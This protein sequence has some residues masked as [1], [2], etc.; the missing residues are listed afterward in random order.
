MQSID[1]PGD[2]YAHSRIVTL[3]PRI[4]VEGGGTIGFPVLGA[5]IRSLIGVAEKAPYGRG[6]DAVF[7]TSVRDCWQIDS[8]QIRIG[9]EG[10]RAA[11]DRILGQVA[12]GLGCPLDEVEALPYKLLVY[13]PGGFFNTHR[14]TEKVPGM[15]GTLVVSIPTEGAGGELVVRHVHR[16]TVI[17]MAVRDPAI[18]SFA[19]FYADCEHET[20]P[21]RDGHRVALVFNLVLRGAGAPTGAPDFS[22]QEEQICK[23]LRS[24]SRGVKPGRKLVWLLEHD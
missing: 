7:D 3:M 10:W 14:D 13:E 5:Q 4:V 20:R 6:P 15:I 23:V 9:G 1:R 2:Y 19:A 12:N 22:E 18:L 24:W 17:D 16:E 11:S 21:V 8:K